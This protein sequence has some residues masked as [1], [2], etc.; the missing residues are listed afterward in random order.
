MS[1]RI[2]AALAVLVLWLLVPTSAA[3]IPDGGASP[4][5]KGT[6]VQVWPKTL[7]PGDTLNFKVTGFPAGETIYIK[8]DDGENC[9]AAAVHGACVIHQQRIPQRGA[10]QGSFKIPSDIGNG[11]HWLRFLASAV[12]YG[13]N[14]ERLGVDP[15]TLRGASDFTVSKATSATPSDNPST[16][17]P[18]NT[19]GTN[20][21]NTGTTTTD[22]GAANPD[23]AS[24][25]TET[26]TQDGQVVAAGDVLTIDLGSQLPTSTATP[27]EA[28]P[29]TP[30]VAAEKAPVADAATGF[31]LVGVLALAI[32][33]LAVLLLLRR[34]AA[35]G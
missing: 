31:P 14:G 8:I 29:E 5:T 4:D 34:P 12:K 20:T 11:K 3:G 30:A 25:D 32:G 23:A 35:R 10:V 1:K 22:A 21:G 16:S 17:G 6:A 28:S 24:T 27:T 19:G 18:G 7:V 26:G 9:S 33:L 13:P 15:F 2:L